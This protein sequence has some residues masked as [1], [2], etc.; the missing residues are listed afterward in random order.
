VTG[1]L[2][3]RRWRTVLIVIAWILLQGAPPL[4]SDAVNAAATLPG[5]AASIAI[6]VLA[7]WP[8]RAAPAL[9]GPA[10]V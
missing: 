9:V 1:C 7:V 3:P 2:A 6:A 5:Q 8:R 4:G 10:G